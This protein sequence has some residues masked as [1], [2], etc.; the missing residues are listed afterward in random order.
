MTYFHKK[1]LIIAHRGASA[2]ATHENTLE[3]FQIAIDLGADMVEF[4][5]RR[6]LDQK[7]IVFHNSSLYGKRIE[8]YTYKEINEITSKEH[9]QVPLLTDVLKLCQGKIS[10]DIELK[11]GGYEEIVLYEVQKYYTYSEYF[12]K[13]FHDEVVLTLK[14]LDP[15]ITAGLLTGLERGDPKTR[16]SEYWPEH[17][18][19][20]CK[21]DFI[22]PH[23]QFLTREFLLRM[24][25]ER[26]PVYPWTV[27]QVGYMDRYFHSLVSGII[28]DRPDL[29]L[30]I[31]EKA[32]KRKEK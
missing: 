20:H 31:R 2:L 7:L 4:D 28:T 11:E 21:A 13:S 3:S 18:L 14:L 24:R 27:N 12:M 15:Q 25:L 29:A 22:S 32:K 6:T 30:K 26:F 10:L 23:Y 9:Y 1:K 19:H 16:I 5:I 17:R 8:T